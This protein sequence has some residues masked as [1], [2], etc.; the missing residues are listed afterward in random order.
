M[1]TNAYE[2]IASSLDEAAW[3]EAR[4]SLVT[5]SDVSAIL[6]L[7]PYRSALEVWARKTGRMA[8]PDLSGNEPVYFGRLLEP[9]VVAEFG[10]RTGRVATPTNVLKRSRAYP[11]LGATEDFDTEGE[12][13]ESKTGSSYAL[14][15]W[16]EG[17]PAHYRP[18]LVTQCIVTGSARGWTAAL[19]GGQRFVYDSVVPTDEECAAILAATAQF[20]ACLHNDT[21]PVADGSTSAAR[22]LF[23]LNPAAVPGKAVALLPD[24]VEVAEKFDEAKMRAA[25]AEGDCDLYANALR[26]FAGDAERLVLPGG[27]GYTLKTVVRAP[28]VLT[29]ACGAT[30]EVVRGASYRPLVRVRK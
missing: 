4:R 9:V 20:A 19:L 14:S 27:G 11:W 8:A 25:V 6:G 12:P 15:D 24:M 16:S 22:A 26:Q 13:G 5:A 18:Q 30:H 1:S 28:K 23:A 3:T 7:N 29:C 10:R 2:V 21:P 17:M